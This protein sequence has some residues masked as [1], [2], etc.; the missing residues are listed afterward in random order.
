[1]TNKVTKVINCSARQ[2][3][4]HWEAVDV[5]YLSYGWLETDSQVENLLFVYH[6]TILRSFQVSHF[7][8]NFTKIIL[9]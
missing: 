7:T 6:F 8:N 4:N 3:P 1:M 9:N 5:A 2:T